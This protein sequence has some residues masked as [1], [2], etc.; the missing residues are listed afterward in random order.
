MGVLRAMPA[1]TKVRL[2]LIDDSMADLRLLTEIATARGWSV[3]VAFNGKDGYHKALLSRFDLILLDVNMP[4]VDGFATC[5]LLKAHA[6]TRHVPVIF[7]SA[8][9]EQQDRLAG[10]LLG[11]EDYI[12]KSY[13]NDEEIAKRI[14]ICLQRSGH[15]VGADPQDPSVNDVL[16][17]A[18]LVH[19]AKKVLLQN[20]A[21]PPTAQE[22]ALQFGS[23]ERKLN[24]AFRAQ[25]G[26]TVFGW[27]RDERLRTA[28][29][30]LVGTD[31]SIV[32]IAE[33]LG[34]STA[35]NFSTAFREHFHG[36]PSQFRDGLPR[37]AGSQ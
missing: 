12:V 7:L 31:L 17:G 37:P 20:M 13:A 29:E 36:T 28:R 3:A 14:A 30:L 9:G 27:L 34:Y 18:A 5:R 11:A 25:Y 35:Q 32:E 4:V 8:A 6:Q 1:A 10:L 21:H 16:P 23:S 2:L 26:L 15:H 24:E 19:A 22:L 33:T